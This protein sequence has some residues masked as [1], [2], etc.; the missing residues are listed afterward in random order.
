MKYFLITL[1]FL[2]GC[3]PQSLEELRSDSEAEMKKLT[4]QLR[5]ME[6][7]EDIQKGQKS[8]K[9]HFNRFA[10]LL[11]TAHQFSLSEKDVPESP[12]ALELFLELARLYEIPGARSKLESAQ[13]EAVIRLDKKI[14]SHSRSL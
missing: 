13:N 6:S 8:L 14:Y 1:I 10:D 7:L 12:A 4:A 5:K 11:I 3:A 2:V 9:K